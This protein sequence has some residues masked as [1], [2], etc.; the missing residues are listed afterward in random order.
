[1][2][3]NFK[4]KCKSLGQSCINTKALFERRKNSFLIPLLVFVLSVFLMSF[5]AYF[6]S[7]QIS[8]KSISEKFPGINEPL[9]AIFNASW[10]CKVENKTLVCD[11]NMEP[12]L[13]VIGDPIQYTV[14][15]N[16]K[17]TISLDTTVVFNTPKNTDNIIVFL[18]NYIRIRYIQRDYVNEKIETYEIIGDYT[19]LEGFDFKLLSQKIADNPSS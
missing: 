2:K 6:N 19:E 11:E 15:A 3:T 12:V 14:L 7:K 9:E 17:G 4:E 18:D 10:D 16:Q 8:S 5:P 13:F 1:M